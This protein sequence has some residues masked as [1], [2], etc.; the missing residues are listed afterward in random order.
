MCDYQ[1][2]LL[3]I[4]FIESLQHIIYHIWVLVRD[5][6][7]VDMPQ[8]GALL[9]VNHL[10]CN[11]PVIIWFMTYPH[12]FSFFIDRLKYRDDSSETPVNEELGHGYQQLIRLFNAFVLMKNDEGNPIHGNW[13][14][15]TIIA[16][17]QEF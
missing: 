13:Q 3:P 16:E 8:H 4:F 6:D 15:L 7:V 12:S 1:Q 11:T 17:F 14:N 9:V 2:R 5:F 10:V